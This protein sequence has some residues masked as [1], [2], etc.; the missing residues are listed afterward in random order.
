MP[1]ILRRLQ[2][3][4]NTQSL[5]SESLAFSL[6]YDKLHRSFH[7]GLIALGLNGYGY[8]IHSLRHGG[9][10]AHWIRGMAFDV[11]KTNYRWASDKSFCNYLAAGKCLMLLVRLTNDVAA[12]LSSTMHWGSNRSAANYFGATAVTI[13]SRLYT[14]LLGV[15][16]EKE[17]RHK[18][19]TYF[20]AE[21][22]MR[23]CNN[24]F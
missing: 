20:I 13:F 2:R 1:L 17:T 24:L 23:R 19:G 18:V 6:S 3:W 5:E 7:Q 11:I 9:A 21:Y 16:T 12:T 10:A 22:L 8:S 15:P 14:T 4:L